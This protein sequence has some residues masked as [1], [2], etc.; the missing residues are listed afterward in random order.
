M[1]VRH[2]WYAVDR[3]EDDHVVLIDDDG[4][5]VEQPVRAFPFRVKEGMVLRVPLNDR[6]RPAWTQAVRDED[7][8]RRRLDEARA[9]LERLKRRDPGGD[10]RL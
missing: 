4:G 3:L 1:S 10:V 6:G 7:E 8:E 9:R 2:T 5:Q